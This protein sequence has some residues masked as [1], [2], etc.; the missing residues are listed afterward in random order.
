MTNRIQRNVSSLMAVSWPSLPIYDL[1]NDAVSITRYIESK[2]STLSKYM[3]NTDLYCSGFIN[4]T[5]ESNTNL[6]IEILLN[7]IWV[8]TVS[9]TPVSSNA[10]SISFNQCVAYSYLLY[11]LVLCAIFESHSSAGE[12]WNPSFLTIEYNIWSA[13]NSFWRP[14]LSVQRLTTL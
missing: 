1:Y 12:E 3:V 2:Y 7:T 6:Q 14:E 11:E 13:I 5:P 9:W 8:S 4:I 10:R